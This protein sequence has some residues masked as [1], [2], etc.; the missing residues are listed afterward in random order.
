MGALIFSGFISLLLAI[1][2]YKAFNYRMKPF[3][4]YFIFIMLSM[5]L[6]FVNYAF[7]VGFVDIELKYLFA[8][9]Q[10]LGIA[11]V[12]VE[13]FLFAA[14]Y[15]GIRKQ[16]VRKYEIVFFL[17]PILTILLILTNSLHKLY[18]ENYYLDIS[19]SFPLLVFE[20]G[21]FFW[22][23][24]IYSFTLIILGIFFFFMQFALLTPYRTQAAVA[25]TA[26]CIPLLGNVLHV[27]HI[28][29]FKSFDPTPFLF[30]ITGL[31]FFWGIMQHKFLNIIPIARENVI[32]S[33][34]DGYI[35]IDLQN[36][37]VDINKSA[38]ELAGKARKEV[39]GRNLNELFGK[40]V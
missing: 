35:V 12:P 9:L 36:S 29:L 17:L 30:A 38:L 23:F 26:I 18:F 2:T 37:I 1:K 40:E 6:W 25:I 14:E 7:E 15:S 31:I 22:I 39:I 28:G 8:R 21:P 20:H 10:Y 16:F 32:E 24:Y 3:S 33:M 5:S 34:S 11:F 4:K 19:G 27:A 13:W